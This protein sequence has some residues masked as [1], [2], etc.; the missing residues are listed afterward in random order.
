VSS[1][2][3]GKPPNGKIATKL[4]LLGLAVHGSQWFSVDQQDPFIAIGNG[5]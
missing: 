2:A 5:R 4:P 1:V 3:S